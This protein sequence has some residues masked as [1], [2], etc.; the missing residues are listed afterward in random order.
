M[1]T[2]YSTPVPP[3]KPL[4]EPAKSVRAKIGQAVVRPVFPIEEED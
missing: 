4:P 3:P 2:F 1:Y